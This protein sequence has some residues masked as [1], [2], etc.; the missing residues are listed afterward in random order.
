MSSRDKVFIL[1][2][3]Y[4]DKV[5]LT[6]E[7]IKS[8][9]KYDNYFDGII[10]ANNNRYDISP[11]AFGTDKRIIVKNNRKNLGYGGG[12]NSVIPE[13]LKRGATHMFFINNDCTIDKPFLFF[14]LKFQ[15]EKRDAG[16]VGA[17][18]KF[19][20][21]GAWVFDIGGRFSS[22]G[23]PYHEEVSSVLGLNP[24]RSEFAGCI[25]VKKEVIEKVK[26]FDENFFLYFEDVDF[27]LR[28]KREGF[29]TY[30]VTEKYIY[31]GL[32]K[33]VGQE[34]KMALYNQSRSGV[35]FAIKYKKPF[36][37][38]EHIL[39]TLKRIIKNPKVSRSALSGLL[40][41]FSNRISLNMVS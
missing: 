17:S 10:I 24:I 16:I 5:A 9:V 12:I 13:A 35:L 23:K 21:E 34:S 1:M 29:N 37:L 41:G 3:H 15:K 18:L 39:I 11:S 28:A 30:V 8:L 33:T 32:S 31:H 27:S 2:S 36:F 22:S 20:R 19:R 14:L 7:C 38:I 4:G 26:G 25:L 40:H 6:S